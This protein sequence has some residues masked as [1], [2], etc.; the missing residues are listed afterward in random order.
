[1][2]EFPPIADCKL[3]A[4]SEL[5]N[6]HRGIP[7]RCLWTSGRERA[8]LFVGEAPGYE[9]DLA[10]ACWIG[11]A[12]QLLAK[13][14]ERMRYIE[15]ADIY[16]GNVCR[17]RPFQNNPP[18]PG[19]INKCKGHLFLDILRL[20]KAYKEIILVALGGPAARGLGGFKTVKTAVKRQAVALPEIAENIRLFTTYHPASLFKKRQPARI[21]AVE[22]HLVLLKRYLMGIFI[23]NTLNIKPEIALEVPEQFPERFTIDIETYGILRGR[24]QTVFNPIKM[25]WIDGI[26]YNKQI[27]TCSIAY[28]DANYK[29]RTA[30]Y[31]WSKHRK[32]IREWF[33]R[34][35]QAQTTVIGQNIKFDLEC[36][37]AAD[38][39]L[40]PYIQPGR[41][42]IDDTMM[43][44]FLLYEQYPEKGLK[45]I[46]LLLGIADYS[47]RGISEMYQCAENEN[48]PRLHLYNCTD[49]GVALLIYEEAMSRIKDK[50]GPDTP[51]LKPICAQTI[52]AVLWGC[53]RMETAGVAF[54]MKKLVRTQKEQEAKMVVLWAEAKSLGLLI[55]GK[56]SD[57]S[58]REFIKS[59]I[60][61]AGLTGD[62]RVL[63][64]PQKKEISHKRDNVELLLNEVADKEDRHK[65][66]LISDYQDAAG[67]ATKFINPLLTNPRK[68]IV[69]IQN[70]MGVAYP[71]WFPIPSEYG[72]DK[73]AAL[74]GTI[75]GRLS[76]QKPPVQNTPPEVDACLMPLVSHDLSQAEWRM[77]GWLSGDEVMLEPIRIGISPHVLGTIRLFKHLTIDTPGLKNMDEYKA[78]KCINFLTI[79]RGGAEAAQKTARRQAGLEKPMEFWAGLLRVWWRDHPVLFEWQEGLM[80][81]VERQGYLILPTGWS[82]YFG[83]GQLGVSSYYN[84]ICNFP[85]QTLTA[86]WVQAA[87]FEIEKDIVKKHMAT[88]IRIQRHDALKAYVPEGELDEYEEIVHT[89]LLNSPL[90]V[91]LEDTTG[92]S[93]PMGYERTI[94]Q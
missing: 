67:I 42:V 29:L 35:V 45:E 90:R 80:R 61:R 24:E 62:K 38:S 76:A 11:R 73:A 5:Y 69:H 40:R 6:V 4:L 83:K 18:T 27:I 33:R 19:Q 84:E 51:K 21:T 39:A 74:G 93:V 91:I 87:H 47:A 53:F 44:T 3:C 60:V 70:N 37:F 30:L 8:I 54:D 71:S 32:I 12:G 55:A 23:P 36:L 64:T 20:S 56:D 92:R 49:S 22:A 31:L 17:C 94:H 66:K 72:Y 13:F 78:T 48:D 81:T 10:G 28:R 34:A 79:Y 46:A 26:P 16:L 9:E 1:M 43:R 85:V 65:L 15:D 89:H 63:L 86:Q 77:A 75:Q 25:W 52:N 59:A 7:T 50:Y 88:R 57:R 2:I 14:I 82:R 58:L 41:L 68:G